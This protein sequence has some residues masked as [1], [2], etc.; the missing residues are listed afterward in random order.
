MI[1]DRLLGYNFGM[2]FSNSLFSDDHFLSGLFE[3]GEVFALVEAGLD[4]VDALH[5]R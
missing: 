2:L 5:D 3:H 4:E 1:P